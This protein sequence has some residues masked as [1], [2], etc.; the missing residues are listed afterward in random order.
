MRWSSWR[1]AELAAR[2]R[3]KWRDLCLALCSTRGEEDK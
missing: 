1:E 3:P 2:D